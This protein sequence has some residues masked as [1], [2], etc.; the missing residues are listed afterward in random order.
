MDTGV[1]DK[2][3]QK[4]FKLYSMILIQDAS[5]PYVILKHRVQG[6][7][8][9]HLIPKR[10]RILLCVHLYVQGIQS[11]SVFLETTFWKRGI[12]FSG[13][14]WQMTTWFKTTEIY[15]HIVS[16][17]GQKP[18]TKVST[19]LIPT[20]NS[21]P[22]S[23]PGSVGNLWHPNAC[24]RSLTLPSPLPSFTGT[25]VIGLRATLNCTSLF[26]KSSL[27]LSSHPQVLSVH[28]FWEATIQPTTRGSWKDIRFLSRQRETSCLN[29]CDHY[30]AYVSFRLMASQT[31]VTWRLLL[32]KWGIPPS[33]YT[34]V[35]WFYCYLAI[36]LIRRK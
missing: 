34:C 36:V 21:G 27:Q 24:R 33:F 35:V 11:R 2:S 4:P 23:F 31:F 16:P 7:S 30:I 28:I 6:L 32:L 25:L 15:S 22:Y 13:L 19:G 18:K 10:L 5:E 26:Q 20:G 17:T 8:Q 29:P 3:T 14:P 12:S 9:D 1:C